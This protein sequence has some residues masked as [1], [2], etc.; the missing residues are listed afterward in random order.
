MFEN[1]CVKPTSTFSGRAPRD[2]VLQEEPTGTGFPPAQRQH[3]LQLPDQPVLDSG[4]PQVPCPHLRPLPAAV[5]TKATVRPRSRPSGPVVTSGG[6]YLL[7]HL[8]SLFPSRYRM[9]RI[10]NRLHKAISLLE[11]FSSQ[12]WEWNS[13][14]LSMLMSQL[15]PEDRKVSVCVC[16]VGGASGLV[17]KMFNSWISFFFLPLSWEPPV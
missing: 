6:L 5:R 8:P 2:V 3:H 13:E 17:R 1:A 12:D 9:M 14:N 10:F 11:Y 15:T 16:V 7:S 4:Q